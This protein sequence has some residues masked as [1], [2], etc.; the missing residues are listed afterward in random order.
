[1]QWKCFGSSGHK[2][3]QRSIIENYIQTSDTLD[4]KHVKCFVQTKYCIGNKGNPHCFRYQK[5]KFCV[6]ENGKIIPGPF[7]LPLTR[8]LIQLNH[9]VTRS[10]EDFKEKRKRGGGNTQ[11]NTKLTQPFWDRFNRSKKE[12]KAILEMR[13][14]L[15]NKK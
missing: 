15:Q 9:Y 11:N 2:K 6:N 5:G 8:K 13:K 14:K 10:E 1:M 4:D 12:C 3:K 7:N